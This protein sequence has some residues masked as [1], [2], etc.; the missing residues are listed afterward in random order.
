[1]TGVYVASLDGGEPRR[2]L[3]AE[4]AAVY[5]PPGYLLRVSQGVL[6]ASRFDAPRGEVSGEAVPVAQSVGT[7]E[8][9]FRDLVSV[10]D[11]GVLAHRAGTGARRQLTW[12]DSSGK[13]ISLLGSPDEA[14]PSAPELSPDESHVVLMRGTLGASDIWIVDTARGV[15]SKLT[16]RGGSLPIWSSTGDRVFYRSRDQLFERPS[17]GVADGR[18]LLASGGVPQDVSPDGRYMLYA[19]GSDLWALPLTG[20]HKP[21]GVAT[22]S[23]F[24]EGQGQFSP[25]GKWIAYASNENEAARH[26]IFV[27]P[28]PG[29]GAKRQV[30]DV[31][32]IYPRWRHDGKEIFYVAPD[33]Q[34]MAVSIQFPSGAPTPAVGTPVALFQTRLATGAYILSSGV[35]ARAQYDV[36]RDGRFLFNNS[37]EE[38][39]APITIVLNWTTLL[40]Q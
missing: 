36:A 24:D 14:V 29:P 16:F 33:G 5:A 18:P 7:R 9:V 3:V 1:V 38:V 2:L 28:F 40:K 4:T 8:G 22:S 34:L 27:R 20:E 26:Q 25:D 15:P 21:I 13:T 23:N 6:L 30:S 39:A 35:N 37:V 10:S 12:V 17:D 19:E 11:T 31:G 32:G